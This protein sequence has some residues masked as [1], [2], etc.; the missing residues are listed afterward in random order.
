MSFSFLLVLSPFNVHALS[1]E[2]GLKIITETG[3]DVTIARSDEDVARD[4]VSL[5]RSPWLPFVDLY[6][7]ETWLQYQPQARTP[8]GAFAT[9]QD[10]FLTY[11]VRAT[12]LLYDFGK[13]SSDIRCR[14][15][16]LTDHGK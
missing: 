4:A 3:R 14:P 1:L 12:Q 8:Y 2:E 16:R 6:G 9:S 7:R 5:A 13:T 15:I 10:Q 11:G